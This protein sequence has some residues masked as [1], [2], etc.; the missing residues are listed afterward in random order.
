MK[1]LLIGVFAIA[2]VFASTS[3]EYKYIQNSSQTIYTN[4]SGAIFSQTPPYIFSFY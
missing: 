4:P 3:R 2:L 1:K